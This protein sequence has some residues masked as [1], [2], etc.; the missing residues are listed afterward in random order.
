MGN[1]LQLDLLNLDWIFEV[2]KMEKEELDVVN[3]GQTYFQVSEPKII[4][5]GQTSWLV[6]DFRWIY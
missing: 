2:T 4:K 3:V 5:I 6:T 1:R